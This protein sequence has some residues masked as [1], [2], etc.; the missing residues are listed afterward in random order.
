MSYPSTLAFGLMLIAFAWATR[1][2]TEQPAAWWRYG[3]FGLFVAGIA[4]IHQFTFVA[5]VLGLIATALPHL[6]HLTARAWG[7]LA[8]S[9]AV[10]IAVLLAWPYYSFFGL[11]SADNGLDAIH[12][13]LYDSPLAY[14]GFAIVAVPALW[15]RS[16]RDKLDP[17]VWFCGLAGALVGY[18]RVTDHWALGRL[19]PALMLAAQ[20]ALAVE[21]AD[22]WTRRRE[23]RTDWRPAWLGLA[24]AVLAT[25]V[26]MQAGNLLFLA[27][28]S[29][30]TAK[31]RGATNT[32]LL[33]PDY[34]WLGRQVKPGDVV[35]TNDY[36]GQRTVIAYGAYTVAPAWPDPFLTDELQRR[37]DLATLVAPGTTEA[38]RQEL[39]LRYHVNWVLET[40]KWTISV[41]Q[42]PVAVGPRGE[43]LYRVGPPR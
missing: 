4:L 15:L 9:V 29:M 14:Q 42:T 20:V 28:R 31:V 3:A 22:A 5:A 16:R 11:L 23:L 39:L 24:V 7:G 8:L 36:F 17:L 34:S 18:G 13:P 40:G 32:F 10:L 26:V 2:L 30:L 6:R 41:G 25:G 27:P 21:L 37:A 33:W 38:T 43:R 35:L 19:W 12:R 1:L